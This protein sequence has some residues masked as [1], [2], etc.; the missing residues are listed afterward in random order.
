[1]PVYRAKRPCRQPG[2][3][4]LVES[5]YCEK[6]KKNE[7]HK[8]D[9][10]RGTSSERGYNA[11]WRKARLI[12]LGK[13]PLCVECEK[14]GKAE[15]GTI[16][17]H[18]IPHKGDMKLFWDTSNWQGLCK[19]HHDI[20]TAEETGFK[21][22]LYYPRYLTPSRIPLFIVCGAPGSGKTT[23]V[24]NHKQEGDLII[25]LDEI[26]SLLSGKPRY[27]SEDGWLEPALIERNRILNGL[28][29]TKRYKRAWFIVGAP[30]AWERDFWRKLK[31]K[32]LIVLETP[33]SECIK[34]IKDR[35]IDLTNAAKKWWL[36]YERDERDIRYD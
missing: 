30:K 20:K 9:D 17:D 33:E 15:P 6:H 23:Y 3:P 8:Y 31:P 24:N 7:W 11:R 12:Y 32:K 34:R 27:E 22:D 21:K 5:G 2:C 13:H 35:P 36:K 18:I 16:I 14:E 1:M 29:Y 26:K 4:N 10:K 25:D 19:R 28:N